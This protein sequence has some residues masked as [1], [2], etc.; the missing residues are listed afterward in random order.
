LLRISERKPDNEADQKNVGGKTTALAKPIRNTTASNVKGKKNFNR[1]FAVANPE[2]GRQSRENREG[3]VGIQKRDGKV[4]RSPGGAVCVFGILENHEKNPREKN[5]L[6]SRKKTKFGLRG[7][8]RLGWRPGQKPNL[9]L[10]PG[11]ARDVNRLS[12]RG[13]YVEPSE[14]W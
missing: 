14:T 7:Q 4:I 11:K 5:K 3:Q 10:K 9:L 13:F 2:G 8:K 6:L 1:A 12:K